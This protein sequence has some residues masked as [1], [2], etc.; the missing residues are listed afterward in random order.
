MTCTLSGSTLVAGVAGSPIDHSL[1]PLIHNAWIEAC[2]IDAI[3]VPF[4]PPPDDFV[5]FAEGLRGAAIRGLNVTLPFKEAALSVANDVS[6]RADR[7]GAANLLLFNDDGSI[8]ADNVDG[9]GLLAAFEA[10]APGFDPQA[11]PAV[12][13]GAGGGA[14]GAAAAFV[15][16]GAPEVRVVN[17]TLA[18]AEMIAGT[19]G[20]PV[21][22]FPLHDA[23]TAFA[24]A[25]AIVNATSAGVIS[26]ESVDLPLEATPPGA[27]VMDMVYRPLETAFLARARR[28]GRKTVDGLEML[29]R[30]AAPS[31]EAFFGCVPPPEVDVRGL[32]VRTLEGEAKR[33][34]E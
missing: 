22:A 34:A 5:R 10:Q 21:Y 29:I 15:L 18:R 9:L 7:A 26:N 4:R 30:Q 1:S 27:V 19:L 31:F 20:G 25:T 32:C 12:I 24:G 28:L 8:M 3:Y 16:A 11:G 2:G 13:V 17:R 33:A 6:V 14:R 23:A